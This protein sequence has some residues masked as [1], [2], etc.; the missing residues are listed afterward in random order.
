MLK[1]VHHAQI[2][3]PSGSEDRARDFYCGVLGIAEIEK[4]ESL[5]NRGGFWLKLGDFQIHFGIDENFDASARANSKAHLAY[6]V[7]DLDNWRERLKLI[8][9]DVIEGIPIPGYTRFEFRDPFN[10]RI[11]FLQSV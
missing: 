3:I 6:L 11:E 7:E 10:N 8:D 4:P 9:I 1:T 5:I 2:I